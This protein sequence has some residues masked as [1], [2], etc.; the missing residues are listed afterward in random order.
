VKTAA[1]RIGGAVGVNG[2]FKQY[3]ASGEE[4]LTPAANTSGAG[5]FVFQEIPLGGAPSSDSHD[6]VPKLQ[7]GVRADLLRVTSKTGDPKFGVGRSTDFDNVSGS[8]G[9]TIPFSAS[10]SIGMSAARAFR[11]PTVE[12]LYSNAFHAA[13][14]TFDVGNPNL[15]S[16]VNQGVDAVLRS[17]TRR[18]NAEVSAYW[19]RISN[20]IAPNIVRDTTTDNG[21]VVPLNIFSQGD[22]TLKGLEGRLEGTV[23]PRVVLGAMGDLVRG[24]FRD[25]SPLPF[26]PAARLGGQARWENGTLSL[27]GEVRHAFAQ[28]RVSGGDVDVPT[29]AYT[30]LNLSSVCSTSAAVWCTRSPCVATT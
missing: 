22:A 29:A 18:V 1:G 8:V 6:L 5:L 9:L 4:A 12:E 16:E 7:V 13:A 10:T 24:E 14:G 11:A 27:S 19:N 3:A 21:N 20:Y 17:Q 2:I 25:G 26:L 30:L 28:D 23:A 15:K